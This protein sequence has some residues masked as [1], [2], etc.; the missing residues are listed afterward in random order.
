M[1]EGASSASGAQ[2]SASYQGRA[3]GDARIQPT[4]STANAHAAA[5]VGGSAGA[6][7]SRRSARASTAISTSATTAEAGATTS[8]TVEAPRTGS[9]RSASRRH[10]VANEMNFAATDSWS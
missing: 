4:A 8:R 5:A 1:N 3:Y 2:A 10:G 7:G 9:S 6:H